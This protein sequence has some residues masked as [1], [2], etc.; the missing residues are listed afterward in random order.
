M[1]G[2]ELRSL[3]FQVRL[4]SEPSWLAGVEQCGPP[5]LL[6]SGRERKL[7]AFCRHMGAS[8]RNGQVTGTWLAVR[9]L[10]GCLCVCV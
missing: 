6:L 7:P 9:Q 5:G 10:L 1:L 2:A 8:A 3:S 4:V